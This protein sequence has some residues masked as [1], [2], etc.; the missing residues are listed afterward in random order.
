MTVRI[1]VATGEP[2]GDLHGAHVYAALK[3][4]FPAAEIEAIGGAHLRR[5]GAFIRAPIEGLGAMGLVEI[6]TAVP[7]HYR[8]LRSLR[9]DFRARRY[10]LV[11]PIDY[12]GFHLYVAESARAAGIPVLWYIAPQLWA[13]RPGRAVKL[14]RAVDRLAVILP[15]E[16]AFFS[17]AGIAAQYVGH[18]LLDGVSRPDRPTA[19][20]RLDLSA[21]V[22]VL[23]VLPGSRPGEIRRLWPAF[24]DAAMQLL[25]TKACDVVLVAGTDRGEYPGSARFRVV[26]DQPRDLLAA[27]DAALAKSGTTTLE[28]ALA[29]VPMVVAY[30]VNPI[31]ARLLRWMMTSRWVALVN[32]IAEREIVPEFLQGDVTPAVLVER[33]RPLLDSR[34]P[35]ARQQRE[36]LA[37]VRRRLGGPGASD[38]VAELAAE[39]LGA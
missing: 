35:E 4:R 14:A 19:R 9:R 33:L 36:G 29:D 8:L 32:L 26:R 38:R 25:D 30:S 17:K 2:S 5:A 31:S 22:R 11:I 7:A 16:P 23:T 37:E 28:T 1:L 15:F 3:Q 39:L 12:P 13:W 20:A 27:A 18:P 34:S 10:D 6:I 21:D 24:R